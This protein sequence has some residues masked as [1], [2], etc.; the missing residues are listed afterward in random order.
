L[1]ILHSVELSKA[2]AFIDNCDIIVVNYYRQNMQINKQLQNLGLNSN[3]SK[4]YLSLLKLGKA[5][6]GLLAK[7]SGVSRPTVYENLTVL[8]HKQL[9]VTGIESGKRVYYAESP[10][11]LKLMLDEQITQTEEL[12]KNIT[13]IYTPPGQRPQIAFYESIAGIRKMHKMS[14]IANQGRRTRFLGGLETLFSYLPIEFF[15]AY[16]KQR[17]HLGI[18]NEVITSERTLNFPKFYTDQK[19]K[20]NL[21]RM[22]LH[23]MMSKFVTSFFTY[24]TTV[25][26]V[27]TKKEGYVIM[28]DSLEFARTINTLFEF[29]WGQAGE[30]TT[31]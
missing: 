23:P 18:W 29:L 6:A 12:I 22:R 25:W 7:A 8:I 20:E 27:P 30:V 15:Q 21:R 1:S 31:K 2:L 28:I 26:I 4:T 19:N 3:Q 24:D 5:S 17:I 11:A 10:N 13:E 9:V 14:L 16:I